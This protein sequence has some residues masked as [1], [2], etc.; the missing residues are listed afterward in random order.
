MSLRPA[1][2]NWFELLVMR[3]D[4]A[5][6]MVVLATSA[7]VELQT[8]G[9]ATRGPQPAECRDLLEQFA[10]LE[11]SYGRYWP[12]A[13]T[14]Q[15][16]EGEEPYGMLQAALHSARE[17]VCDASGVIARLEE[18]THERGELQALHSMFRHAVSLPDL[19]R[20]SQAGPLLQSCAFQL[21]D[22]KW[23][24]SL[25][26]SVI[27]ERIKAPGHSYLLAV[28][29]P[30]QVAVL[31]G[32]LVAH[33]ARVLHLPADLPPAAA[34]AADLTADRIDKL[35]TGM[36][37]AVADLEGLNRQHDIA[38][39]LTT[40]RFVQWYSESVPELSTTENLAWITGWTSDADSDHLSSLLAEAGI[41]G[42]LRLTESP[43]GFEPPL[44][45]RNPPWL[46]PFETFTA[47]MG[48]PAAGEA[49]P[50]R[51]LAVVSPL[52]FAYMFGDV[53]HGAALLIAG[54]V[55][56]RRFPPLRLLVYGGGMS[57]VFGFLFGSVFALETIIEPL[58]MSPLD[59][60][61]LALTVPMVGGA[62]LLLVG[63]LLEA[64]QSYWSKKGRYWWE[65]GAGLMLCYLSLLGSVVDAR[66]LWTAAAGATWFAVGHAFVVSERRL[67][68]VGIGFAELLE[69]TLRLVVNTVSFVRVGAFALAH[70]G[71]SLAVVGL[72]AA[73]DSLTSSVLVLVL[74]N[75]VIIGLEGLVVSI[76][77]T[78][79][80]LFEF[81][82]RFLGS[83]GRPFRPLAPPQ[84]FPLREHRR[85]Q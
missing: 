4:L 57:V 46:K 48:V 34:E 5:E 81:F 79:L 39:A 24:E 80:V 22:D 54:L 49:D 74:G 37:R 17:W 43:P 62:I 18:L 59:D 35:D 51:I 60:P 10:S 73:T 38:A 77:T 69:A 84:S 2:A 36:R 27:V 71:L 29:L 8:H 47:L 53:G 44:L 14:P 15:A 12:P 63:M 76:Q 82:T 9:H 52:M 70:S 68:A 16:R 58:W 66:W 11:R 78:R 83:G 75:V 25:P 26:G 3:D 1:A 61:V 55:L 13:A 56:S 28:G 45:L 64:V 32:Q 67:V 21:P 65:T 23:P 6:A 85:E 42:V 33:R 40:A 20:I 50:T 72:A 7:S 41:K 19:E 31:T 30:D